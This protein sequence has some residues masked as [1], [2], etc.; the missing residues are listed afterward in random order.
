MDPKLNSSRFNLSL[1]SKIRAYKSRMLEVK[2][3][4][5]KKPDEW[6]RFQSEFNQEIN[7]IFRD[8]MIF[9]KERLSAG[10]EEKEYKLKQMFVKKL[11]H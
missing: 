2:D 1:R 7:G 10:Q 11:R 8:I 3:H 9:E 6:G 5:D 4:L